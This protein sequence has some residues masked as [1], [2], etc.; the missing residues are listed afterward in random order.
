MGLHSASL[1]T[2]SGRVW[3][4]PWQSSGQKGCW[5][6]RES[7][8]NL[9]RSG[10]H[11]PPH[12]SRTPSLASR[13]SAIQGSRLKASLKL[14]PQGLFPLQKRQVLPKEV[15]HRPAWPGLIPASFLNLLFQAG[16]EAPALPASPPLNLPS[17][18]PGSRRKHLPH[19]QPRPGLLPA[20]D[21]WGAEG[22]GGHSLAPMDLVTRDPLAC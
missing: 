14:E 20:Q 6:R 21:P 13:T 10:V 8:I 4:M 19:S 18:P 5:H 3:L 22:R 9:E 15:D 11:W 7:P 16:R 1:T 2:A 17:K 12:L